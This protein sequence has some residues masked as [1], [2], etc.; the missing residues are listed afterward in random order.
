MLLF[1]GKCNILQVNLKG[2]C[3]SHVDYCYNEITK[4]YKLIKVQVECFLDSMWL[5]SFRFQGNL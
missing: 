5:V 1:M 4:F 2:K 3:T